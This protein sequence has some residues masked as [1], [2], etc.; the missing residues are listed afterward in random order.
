MATRTKAQLANDILEWMGVKPAGQSVSGEHSN[1]VQ[2]VIDSVYDQ[3]QDPGLAPY[4][5]SA[6]P[7]WAQLPMIK[8]V[9]VEVGPRFGKPYPEQQ[10]VTAKQE[11]AAAVFGG[12]RP[13][14][15]TKSKD[16]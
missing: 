3:L 8:Y 7:E 16:Y 9:A 5:L 13:T 2:R 15:P 6:I 11:M 10:K 14:L 4:G 1:F 12:P